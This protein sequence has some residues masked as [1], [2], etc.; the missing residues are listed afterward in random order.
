MKKRI[1]LLCFFML[2]LSGCQSPEE[3]A[4]DGRKESTETADTDAAGKELQNGEGNEE[5]TVP[6][7]E[8]D[9][10]AGSVIS[11]TLDEMWQMI[12]EG[13][14]FAIVFMKEN[15]PYCIEF[16]SVFEEYAADHNVTLY[17]VNLSQENRSEN[18][19]TMI[20]QTYFP[21]FR[22][23]EP[24]C[25]FTGC[26]HIN[27]PDCGVKEALLQGE[28]SKSRYEN[29]CQLYGELKDRRKY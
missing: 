29:Y 11:V 26:A 9:S 5:E 12:S 1:V 19:N 13:Q 16:M 21:E 3:N 25:R 10:S 27:E 6:A 18:D 23:W 28:I 8:R 7:Y 2:L 15:C 20:I 22:K 17:E 4:A 14:S 24:Q